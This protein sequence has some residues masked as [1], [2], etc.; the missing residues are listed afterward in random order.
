MDKS[1][2]RDIIAEKSWL[3]DQNFKLSSGLAS[4]YFFN[5]KM[6]ML[7]PQGANLIADAML[8]VLDTLEA[9]SVGGMAVGGV[10]LVSAIAVKSHHRNKS[11]PAFFVRKDIK[12]HG[13]QTKI[14][15]HCLPNTHVVLVEDVTT[16]GGSI[17]QA[18]NAVRAIGCTVTDVITVVDRLEGARDNLAEQGIQLHAILTK[19]DFV[20]I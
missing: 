5:M 14:D 20:S 18:V 3:R 19:D 1:Q 9:H 2:L 13:V 8:E 10:P 17:M 15:G 4:N 12:D 7:H 11:Y 6:T 16:T